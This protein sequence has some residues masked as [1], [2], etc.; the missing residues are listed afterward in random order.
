MSRNYILNSRKDLYSF[1]DDLPHAIDIFCLFI[2]KGG[3]QLEALIPL[4]LKEFQ[5]ARQGDK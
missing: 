4:P 2:C 5:F 1:S 3:M